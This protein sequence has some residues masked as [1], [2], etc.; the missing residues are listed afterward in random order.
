MLQFKKLAENIYR[1][2]SDSPVHWKCNGIMVKGN[3]NSGNIL[4]DCNF[5]N[6]EIKELYTMLDNKID[7]Y[8]V[9]HVHIDHVN[10][11]HNYDA[12]DIPIY[13]P[14]PEDAYLRNIVKLIDDCGSNDLKLD[15][16]MKAFIC[17]TLGFKEPNNVLGF[18]PDETF[19]FGETT[20]STIHL[21]GHS[22][23]HCGFIIKHNS[24]PEEQTVLFGSDM[25]LEVFGMWYGFKYC[26]LKEI[27]SSVAK[28][29]N[30]Y[31]QRDCI[32][33]GSHTPENFKGHPDIF[34]G[35]LEKIDRTGE[36]VLSSLNYK[37]PKGLV[38]ITFQ[39][40]YYQKKAIDKMEPNQKKLYYIWEWF[41]LKHHLDELEE[42]R[43]IS[44][45]NHNQWLL[46]KTTAHEYELHGTK[47]KQARVAG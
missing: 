29:K 30:I 8:F 7:A 5:Q 28:L 1:V 10:N 31:M 2:A 42:K 11:L 19:V 13:C 32:L 25:G 36:R 45:V 21:P 3:E 17:D 12:Y 39:G 27:R 38:D 40:L 22:T 44:R 43:V 15:F 34:K 35:I 4:I 18:T 23:G 14:T 47:A 24:S 41:T 37:D 46:N 26:N 33:I 6:E 9:T 16:Q 20:I